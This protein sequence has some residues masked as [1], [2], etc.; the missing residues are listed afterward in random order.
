MLTHKDGVISR[1]LDVVEG[2]GFLEIGCTAKLVQSD[3]TLSELP[4]SV[5]EDPRS[6][7]GQ[8]LDVAIRVRQLVTAACASAARL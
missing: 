5:A 4:A 6:L 2:S 1:E 3:G 7:L 8:E